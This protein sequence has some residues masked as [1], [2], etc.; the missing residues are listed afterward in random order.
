[1]SL[2]MSSTSSRCSVIV[3]MLSAVVS[4]AEAVPAPTLAAS[5]SS[6]VAICWEVRV[7]VPSESMAAVTAASP[8]MS[9]GS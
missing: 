9:A 1:M 5:V 8:G 6:A 4:D 7:L 2:A 3:L